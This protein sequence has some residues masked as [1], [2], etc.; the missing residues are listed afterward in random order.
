MSRARAI[1]SACCSATGFAGSLACSFA[2]V[3]AAIGLFGAAGSVAA[4]AK[5][6][7]G[8]M[9]SMSSATAHPSDWLD[10][11]V[12]NGPAILIASVALM[13]LAVALRRPVTAAPAL[14]GGVILY[15]GMYRQQSLSWMYAAIAVGTLL[16]LAAIVAGFRTRPGLQASSAAS[17]VRA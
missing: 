8:A 5:R 14:A 13:T 1:V 9:G 16:L 3:A 7:M 10:Y 6:S 11:L 4:R 15:V 17:P 12:R 2:M